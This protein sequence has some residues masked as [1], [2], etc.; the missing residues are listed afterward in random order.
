M[1]MYSTFDVESITISPTREISESDPSYYRKIQVVYE[2][3]TALLTFYST[4]KNS[5][6]ICHD[7]KETK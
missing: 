1:Q 7:I 2:G 6:E 3:G 5:L 4:D